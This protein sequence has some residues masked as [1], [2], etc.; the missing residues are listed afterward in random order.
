MEAARDDGAAAARGPA[1]LSAELPDARLVAQCRSGDE[2]AWRALVE[3]FSRYVYAI[4][5]QAFRLPEHDAEDVFQEVFARVYERLET[6]RE[7]EAV[8]PWIGQLT[9][10]LCIDRLRAGS[11]ETVE[12]ADEL[13]ETAADDVLSQ[14]EEAFDVH[15]AMAGLPENCRE[16]L[17]RFFAR[18]ESYRTIGDALGLPAGTIASRIS[19]CLDKLRD[20]LAVRD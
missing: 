6:L 7:D 4:S 12:D 16:I 15:D 19:R 17:D 1:A 3:R 10:R 5:V 8:R 13:P 2:E 18:D 20:V 9:R 14:I 11:R